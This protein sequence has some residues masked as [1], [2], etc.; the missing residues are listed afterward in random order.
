MPTMDKDPN[1][2]A[3]LDKGIG[4]GAAPHRV[5][6]SRRK[7]WQMP[8]NTILVTR[9]GKWGNPFVVTGKVR[10]GAAVGNCYIAVPTVE[11]AV[12]A[13]RLIF[14]CKGSTADALR[15][16]LPELRGKNL[17]CWCALD[18]PCHANVL[19]QLA[20]DEHHNE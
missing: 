12:E 18:Q 9:P 8:E 5:R 16:A 17:A 4:W 10:P 7:G 11:D 3:G 15:A 13:Y 1:A 6:L 14:G 2:D 20:N 19:L